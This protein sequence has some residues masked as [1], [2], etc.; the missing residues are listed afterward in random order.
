MFFLIPV[1][2]LSIY[3]FKAKKLPNLPT[4]PS[5]H[6]F[7]GDLLTFNKNIHRMN[8]FLLESQQ[9]FGKECYQLS[10]P[11][12]NTVYINLSPNEE[13]MK[14]VLKDNF[15]NYVKKDESII[16]FDELLG[17]GIFA[18]NGDI[19]KTQRKVASHM[20]S[21]RKLRDHMS[22]IFIKHSKILTTKLD[23]CAKNKSIIDIQNF[24]YRYTASAFLEIGFG[25]HKDGI[26]NDLEFTKVFDDTQ[27]SM[28][29]RINRL[30]WKQE[31]LFGCNSIENNIKQNIE[32][33]NNFST[34]CI[35]QST[36]DNS[37]I[38][39]YKEDAKKKGIKLSD[40]YLRDILMNFLIAGRDTTAAALT[41]TIYRMCLHPEILLK[42][43]EEINAQLKI[44]NKVDYN[45]CKNCT[46]LDNVIN[47][48]L[49]LHPS[50]PSDTKYALEDD[51]LPDG[52]FIPKGSVL[53]YRPYIF[54]RSDLLWKDPLKFDP[55]RWE[56]PIS[57]YK[58]I[59]FNAGPRLCLG[60]SV[61]ILEMKLLLCMFLPRYNFTRFNLEE[62]PEWTPSI[63]L[64][65]KNGLKVVLNKL[66]D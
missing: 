57:Q 6:W 1:I 51:T 4:L 16:I 37:L 26:N 17:D 38:S 49:R 7:F 46:Y 56:E 58:Y 53:C 34:E 5:R 19:W 23:E 63:I 44:N 21:Q 60:K 50:V 12:I 66:N 31:R 30:F 13:N 28:F 3:F 36:S 24:F 47:E 52:T 29:T 43:R 42:C 33:L 8:D 14:W 65:M 40:K 20:F 59:T 62:N 48:V 32:Y 22:E 11:F 2:L 15:N 27:I 10:F 9:S 61:A 18:Q 41:W 35:K 64:T 55:S 45:L 54:G 25:I 39:M